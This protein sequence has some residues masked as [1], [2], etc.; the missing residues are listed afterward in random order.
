MSNELREAAQRVTG[1]IRARALM[2]NTDP[3]VISDIAVMPA[4][5]EKPME[6]RLRVSDLEALVLHTHGVASME[7]RT[8]W[9][10]K[11]RCADWVPDI[12]GV[13]HRRTCGLTLDA[14][15]TCPRPEKEHIR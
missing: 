5:A 3:E 7:E 14:N 8:A 4:G 12:S 6:F 15:G 2:S 11:P 10:H 9:P 13:S 1:Y